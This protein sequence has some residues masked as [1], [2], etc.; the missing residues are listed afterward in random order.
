MRKLID[1]KLYDTE[2]AT[3]IA[4]TWNGLINSDFR[5]LDETIYKTKNGKYFLYGHGGAM[6][7]YAT[8]YGGSTGGGSD[9]IPLTEKEVK[10][11]LENWGKTDKYFELF[12]KP[13]EA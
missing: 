10:E 4:E 8:S 3:M 12:G 6:T 5:N 13:E 9:I 11:Y 7:K 1:G 2:T